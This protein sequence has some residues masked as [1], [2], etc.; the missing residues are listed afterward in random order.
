[1]FDPNLQETHT[2]EFKILME[3][4]KE[5]VSHNPST[6]EE[7]RQIISNVR[8]RP[9]DFA[10]R[11][12]IPP[13]TINSALARMVEKNQ[14]MWKKYKTVQLKMEQNNSIIHLQNHI[15][16]VQDFLLNT[17]DLTKKESYDEALRL[18]P[19]MSCKL[20]KLICEKYHRNH[21]SG[22]VIMYPECHEHREDEEGGIK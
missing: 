12:A 19:N 14:I 3:F 5:I 22:L 7:F 4:L 20:A 8:I 13:Q 15:H 2:V 9:S 18:A 6:D 1:M 11:L 10:E 21:C 16:L 17:L